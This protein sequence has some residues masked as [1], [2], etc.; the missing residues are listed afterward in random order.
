MLASTG[1]PLP[2][3]AT[4]DTRLHPAIFAQRMVSKG[5]T[6]L[7]F[8]EACP[9]YGVAASSDSRCQTALRC[10][11]PGLTGRSS[12]PEAAVLEPSGRRIRCPAFAGHDGSLVRGCEFAFSRRLASELCFTF[13]PPRNTEGAGKAGCWLH[14]WVPCNKKHGGRTTGNRSIPAFPARWC[15]GFL[16]ALLGDRAFLPPS[17]CSTNKT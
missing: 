7:S 11:H 1:D 14:P 5:L 12:L 8:R 15:Y 4:D 6:A 2:S 16:R 3:S 9:P 17:L 10:H 13:H